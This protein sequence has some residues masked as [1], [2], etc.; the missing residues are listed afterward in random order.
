MFK[1]IFN[2]L[3]DT[4]LPKLRDVLPSGIRIF[5]KKGF[6]FTFLLLSF[7]TALAK[8]EKLKKQPEK[9]NHKSTGDK[10]E[11]VRTKDVID[12][13]VFASSSKEERFGMIMGTT[14]LEEAKEILKQRG[15]EFK[16]LREGNQVTLIVT[17][18][19]LIDEYIPR[20][21][22]ACLKIFSTS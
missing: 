20:F 12:K 6:L 5:A 22:R 15:A 9:I 19:P 4:T 11:Q 13:K 16:E 18:D 1:D 8:D 21:K 10:Q 2:K 7:S 3:R 14:K 17:K